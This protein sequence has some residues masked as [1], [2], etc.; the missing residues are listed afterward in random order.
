MAP[1][2]LSLGIGYK[3]D[4][5]DVALIHTAK[6]NV[7]Q[8]QKL[9]LSAWHAYNHFTNLGFLAVHKIPNSETTLHLAA[10]HSLTSELNLRAKA[11][12]VVGNSRPYLTFGIKQKLTENLKM[13]ITMHK[14][15]N[16]SI[17]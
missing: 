12:Y 2:L 13:L 4:D 8:P 9:S 16:F 15:E 6:D 11:Q 7:S 10:D 5:L 14:E 1:S 17:G 3:K